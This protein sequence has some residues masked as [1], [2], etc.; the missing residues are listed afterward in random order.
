M[1]TRSDIVL[2]RICE[3]AAEGGATE[4]YLFPARVP[5]LRLYGQ[6]VFLVNEEVLS[7]SL[8]EEIAD[9]LLS[10]EEKKELEGKRQF[11]KVK[12]IGKI[13]G[14][15]VRFT[16]EEGQL[17]I[18]LKLLS[19][20]LE[21]LEKIDLPSV[22]KNF[23]YL[24]QGVVFIAGPRDAGRSTL[25]ASLLDYINKNQTRFIATVEEPIRYKLKSDKSVIE[26]REVGKDVFS[27]KEG[28]SHIKR[29]NVD[30]AYISS[31]L[32]PE[33]LEE[34]LSLAEAG[35]LVFTIFNAESSIKT[36][37]RI[38][39][40]F[41]S[42]KKDSIR[43]LLADN[44]GGVIATRLVPKSG[45]AGRV[46]ALEILPG[47]ATV[48]SLIAENKISQLKNILEMGTDNAVFLDRHLSDLVSAGEITYEDGLRYSLN[49]DRFNSLV[50]R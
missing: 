6:I 29:R 4:V 36:I 9:F 27:F 26:Q 18:S 39:N 38:I 23:T 14:V 50:R 13:G 44:L 1:S 20:Q 42:D 43:Y 48:K 47:S 21:D 31:C 28:I 24:S 2:N 32:E 34:L 8:I 37:N 40:F 12:E 11:V 7:I 49:K 30:V 5:S 46:R 19:R 10:P 3:R 35:I 33:I 16:F 45:G 22:V 17:S 25:A 41:P 15:E